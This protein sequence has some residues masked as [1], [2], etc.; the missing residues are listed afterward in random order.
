MKLSRDLVLMTGVIRNVVVE[1]ESVG[2][3]VSTDI[4]KKNYQEVGR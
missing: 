3:I 4:V 1:R 2:I